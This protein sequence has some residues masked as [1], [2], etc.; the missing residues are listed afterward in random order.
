MK[1]VCSHNNFRI[2]FRSIS[3][4]PQQ[5]D[6][7]AAGRKFLKK[8]IQLQNNIT[9]YSVKLEEKLLNGGRDLNE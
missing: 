3:G 1:N 5:E 8:T 2:L 4:C 6:K 7:I 9:D